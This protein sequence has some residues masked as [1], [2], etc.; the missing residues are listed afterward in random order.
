MK[1]KIYIIKKSN[2]KPNFW[3]GGKTFEYYIYPK[4]AD[5]V[6]KNFLFRI[7][8][9]SIEK[10]P[11]VFT[12]FEHY[13]RYLVMLN[14]DLEII[15]NTQLELY[16]ELEIFQFSSEDHISSLALGQDFNL[17]VSDQIKK[18]SLQI[19]RAE[20]NMTQDFIFC[21]AI[22]NTDVVI[23]EKRF[24]LETNDLLIIE[25]LQHYST[26]IHSSERIIFGT[27]EI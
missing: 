16:R 4:D 2:I 25:N 14:S 24:F 12:N 20:K 13:H 19:I 5:Y 26:K 8:S 21:F 7:S 23:E 22:K 9:A 3:T 17:M 11:S 1:P 18:S 15:R 10:T 27:I 6:D